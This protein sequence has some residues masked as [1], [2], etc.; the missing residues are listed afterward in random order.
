MII[1]ISNLYCFIPKLI[2]DIKNS[3]H[4]DSGKQTHNKLLS[5]FEHIK[6]TLLANNYN[7]S[8]IESIHYG[9]KASLD[10][11][12][13]LSEWGRREKWLENPLI[14]YSIEKGWAGEKFFL[15]LDD[16]TSDPHKNID[17]I[18]IFFEFIM[19]GY[20]GKY[21]SNEKEKLVEIKE[22][23]FSIINE[24]YQSNVT[25]KLKNKRSIYLGISNKPWVTSLALFS[26]FN[27]ILI[28][29]S[30]SLFHL[31]NT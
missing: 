9:F 28:Q 18:K 27:L 11:I 16:L 20:E 10:E 14:N 3:L 29:K 17:F 21:Y 26:I 15:I 31:L 8:F 25:N 23:V 6:K 19:M 2:F 13:S 12:I 24:H 22:K 4:S 5:E 30:I 7:E 1:R